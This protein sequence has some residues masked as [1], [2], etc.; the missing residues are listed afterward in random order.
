MCYCLNVEA[1]CKR[2]TVFIKQRPEVSRVVTT[3]NAEVDL[4]LFFITFYGSTTGRLTYIM[5]NLVLVIMLEELFGG[6]SLG[7]YKNAE[8]CC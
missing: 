2:S 7:L 5:I 4:D 8:L 3:Q 6:T 1:C